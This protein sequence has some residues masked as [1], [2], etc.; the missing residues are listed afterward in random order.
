[1]SIK[2]AHDDNLLNLLVMTNIRFSSFFQ[3]SPY[4]K[5]LPPRAEIGSL[6]YENFI[7]I[8]YFFYI[9]QFIF[10]VKLQVQRD[11]NK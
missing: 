4:I 10:I 1:V 11:L 3:S 8:I 5:T 2:H 9:N 7:E 6:E